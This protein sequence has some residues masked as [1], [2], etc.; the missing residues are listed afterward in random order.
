M[1]S[2]EC[3]S[4]RMIARGIHPGSPGGTLPIV[5]RLLAVALDSRRK[6]D[7]AAGPCEEP[8]R[9]LVIRIATAA[10]PA[11]CVVGSLHRS[12]AWLLGSAP[13]H[14]PQPSGALSDPPPGH[15]PSPPR[16][17]RRTQPPGAGSAPERPQPASRRARNHRACTGSPVAGRAG[18][19][20]NAGLRRL[21]RGTGILPVVSPSFR[22]SPITV[23]N[24]SSPLQL[25]GRAGEGNNAG[26]RRLFR[27]TGTARRE[28]L[29]PLEP[30]NGQEPV[31]S[32][33]AR[34]RIQK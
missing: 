31:K 24:R 11:D 29:F 2:R 32:P 7:P 12:Q 20:N 4:T 25:A 18:E 28:P 33:S 3:A 14:P 6:I 23:R 34:R 30:D 19:G 15:R 27:G 10:D 17:D 22:S 9:G 5:G 26:L 8:S 1:S 13:G 16:Q 21:F